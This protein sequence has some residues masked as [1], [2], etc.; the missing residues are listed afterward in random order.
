MKFLV[1]L[2]LAVCLPAIVYSYEC[3]GCDLTGTWRTYR[4]DYE[5]N[6]D[7][8]IAQQFDGQVEWI[9]EYG[10]FLADYADWVDN[11]KG[12]GSRQDQAR[13]SCKEAIPDRVYQFRFEREIDDEDNYEVRYYLFRGFAPTSDAWDRYC[14]LLVDEDKLNM[15]ESMGR[16]IGSLKGAISTTTTG[17]IVATGGNACNVDFRPNFVSQN[18]LMKNDNVRFPT[19]PFCAVAQTGQSTVSRYAIG[20]ARTNARY[21]CDQYTWDSDSNDDNI[22][23]SCDRMYFVNSYNEQNT[24]KPGQV[25]GGETIYQADVVTPG[26]LCEYR[27]DKN[28]WGGFTEINGH[29][30]Q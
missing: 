6:D 29:P 14:R 1:V 30:C 16:S 9:E 22:E 12:S 20:G 23:Q 15:V 4:Q 10:Q 2:A 26:D 3:D 19:E 13:Q 24:L 5:N 17:K 8:L 18:C 28:G 25:L 11:G 7:D 27:V 21:G